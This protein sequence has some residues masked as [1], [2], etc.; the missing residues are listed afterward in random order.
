MKRPLLLLTGVLIFL[1][2]VGKQAMNPHP[3]N[4][5]SE[6]F[7][8][9]R[10]IIEARLGGEEMSCRAFYETTYP[11]RACYGWKGQ[12]RDF[13]SR[14][15]REISSIATVGGWRE[16]YAVWGSFFALKESPDRTFGVSI[17]PK[18]A[19][20]DLESDDSLREFDLLVT[21]TVD[22]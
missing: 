9:I 20:P 8:K 3:G 12:T 10:G 21:L 22:Q 7:D 5:S 11:L 4:T 2:P 15:N 13:I 14:F 17:A 1:I 16:D 19:H 6:L 18:V